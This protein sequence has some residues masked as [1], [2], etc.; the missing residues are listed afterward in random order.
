MLRLN[1]LFTS[2]QT[3]FSGTNL[4][5]L[6]SVLAMALEAANAPPKATIHKLTDQI[7]WY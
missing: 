6:G 1:R 2:W 4:S 5:T 7:L 3:G